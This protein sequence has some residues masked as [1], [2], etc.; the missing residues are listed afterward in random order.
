MGNYS[1]KKLSTSVDVSGN[2]NYILLINGVQ[3]SFASVLDEITNHINRE[4]RTTALILCSIFVLMTLLLIVLLMCVL[5]PMY[6]TISQ[7]TILY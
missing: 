1:S 5:L 7:H 2:N 6:K 3:V 4:T